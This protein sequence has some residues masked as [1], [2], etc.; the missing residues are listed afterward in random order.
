MEDGAFGWHVARMCETRNV[1]EIW[2][3][4]PAGIQLCEGGFCR[5]ILRWILWRYVVQ[6]RVFKFIVPTK[7]I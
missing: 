5:M 1:L 4:R 7:R 6:I 3:G 2:V